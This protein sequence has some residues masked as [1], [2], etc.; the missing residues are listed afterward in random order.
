MIGTGGALTR[1]PGG[2]ESLQLARGGE[3]PDRLLPPADA[4]CVL[5]RAYI[6]ACCGALLGVFEAE[7]VVELMKRSIGLAEGH[8]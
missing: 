7:A 2:V 4:T 6:F 1:L 8:S 3:G 5:D